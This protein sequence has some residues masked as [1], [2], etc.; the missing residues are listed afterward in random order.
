[1]DKASNRQNGRRRIRWMAAMLVIMA[2]WASHS[3]AWAQATGPP[4]SST[5]LELSAFFDG[6]MPAQLHAYHVPGAV[7]SVVRDGRMVFARGYGVA[8]AEIGTPVVADRT[9]FRLASI[10]KLFV[11]TAVMQQVEAGNLDL[12]ADVNT[13][14]TTFKIPAT[15]SEPITLLHLMN[16]TA[17]FE[18]RALRTSAR[19]PEDI[20]PLEAF[21]AQNMP[22]RVR[23]PGELTAYSNYGAALAGYIVGAV[24]GMSFEEYV[25]EHLFAPLAM[26]RSTLRQ[27]LPGELAPDLAAGHTYAGGSYEPQAVE[28]A[29]LAPAASLSATATD[30]ANFMIA[31][32]QY[33]RFGDG[34]FGDG[35]FDDGGNSDRRILQESTASEMQRRSFT[36]DPRVNGYAHGFAEASINGQRLLGHGG[37]TLY[38]HSAL[39]LL[40]QYNS[41]FFVAFN[42]ANGLAAVLNTVEAIMDY[43]YPE[44][45]PAPA[46]APTLQENV[47]QYAGVYF[48]TRAEYTTAGKMVRMLQS[49][50]VT[51]DGGQ[52]LAVAL[53]FPA[54]SS[55]QYTAVAPGVFQAKEGGSS[56][57]FGDV[58]FRS[59]DGRQL[60]FQQNNPSTAYVKAPW[61][62]EPGFNLA[63][64]G[65][66]AASLLSALVWAPVGWWIRRGQDETAPFASRL[67]SWWQQLL[68]LTG[69]LFLVGFAAI[70]SN[71][72]VVFGLSAWARSLFLLPLPIAF[73]AAGMVVF[74]IGAWTRRWWTL[75]GRLH[76]TLVSL[77]ALAFT[78]WLAYWNLWI[79]YLR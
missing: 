69:V 19:R 33:G 36:N 8:N 52:R 27:P 5:A 42:G 29:Q 31:H 7:V 38:F 32:L 67:A 21:L 40:P 68:S 53:G 50:R 57:L 20:Q 4:E 1:M 56:S 47:A 62:A 58:V 10:S 39:Y 34:R 11:W 16:H 51:P 48:P 65:G 63:L 66:V 46:P 25:E 72:E 15:Y 44:R 17:G 26:Q 59:D 76:Y 30:M 41:G 28:W 13:Y 49:I 74:T 73:L 3:T 64:L 61:Y 71:P 43:Y 14:L 77:A 55:G 2:L 24:S 9:L 75:P 54:Q 37:D 23:P 78:W 60:L 79:G 70:F 18:E 35:R 45:Q 6:L 12:D 22:A